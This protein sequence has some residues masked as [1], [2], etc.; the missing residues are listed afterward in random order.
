MKIPRQAF[1]QAMSAVNTVVRVPKRSHLLGGANTPRVRLHC[2]GDRDPLWWAGDG[3][4][5][6]IMPLTCQETVAEVV[7]AMTHA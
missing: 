6:L 7:E 4:L 3:K 2:S 5:Y 1:E